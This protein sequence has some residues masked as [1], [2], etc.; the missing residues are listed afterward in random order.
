MKTIIVLTTLAGAYAV[1]GYSLRITSKKRRMALFLVAEVSMTIAGGMFWN[2]GLDVMEGTGSQG[3]LVFLGLALWWASTIFGLHGRWQLAIN[4]VGRLAESEKTDGVPLG[5]KSR[6]FLR[7]NLDAWRGHRKSLY[8]R[9]ASNGVGAVALGEMMRVQGISP[10]L[11]GLTAF[12]V[13]ELVLLGGAIRM[14]KQERIETIK[15]VLA[16]KAAGGC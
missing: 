6:E 3:T 12:M 9:M 1:L 8:R 5:Q 4:L 10:L 16:K 14:V 11:I 2:V 7:K 13:T 15:D